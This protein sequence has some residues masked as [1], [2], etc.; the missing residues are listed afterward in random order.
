MGTNLM[1]VMRTKMGTGVLETMRLT[2]PVEKILAISM[3]GLTIGL[4]ISH[5][6]HGMFSTQILVVLVM[7][8]K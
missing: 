5:V 8:M 7:L 2:R 6:L 4:K 3:T 1:M